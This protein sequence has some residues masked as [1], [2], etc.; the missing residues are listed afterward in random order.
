MPEQ[1]GVYQFLDRDG[2]LIYV[3]KAK[4]LK[5]RINSYFQ[6]E[7]ND[8]KTNRMVSKIRAIRYI[9]V[10]SEFDAILLENNLIK[11]NQPKYNVEL[12]DDKSYPFVCVT[13]EHFPKIYPTR[14]PQFGRHDYYGPYA[15]VG[16]MNNIL[17]LIRELYPIRTCNLDLS[18]EKIA[19]GNYKVCLEYHIFNCKGPCENLESEAAYEE[20]IKGAKDILKG[21]LKPAKEY[22]QDQMNYHAERMEFEK[23]QMAKEKLDKLQHY[24]SKSLIVNP[25]LDHILI[26]G[27]SET[28]KQVFCNSLM[29]HNG[30][31]TA[32]EN[33]YFKKKTGQTPAEV[34][35]QL[36]AEKLKQESQQVKTVITNIQPDEEYEEI[37]F[38]FPKIGDKKKA[39]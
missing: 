31:I 19:K 34:L 22:F 1:P 5:K 32:T 30:Y 23:A 3:G 11:E 24:Q 16:L 6:K 15:S 27:F 37:D 29:I 2:E 28:E 39:A 33:H 8:R 21:N 35:N 13:R 12:K 20:Y 18:P 4:N 9:L 14:R 17:E 25:K 7:H 26:V 38:V 36:L 10:N